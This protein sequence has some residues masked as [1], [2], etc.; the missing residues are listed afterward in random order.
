MGDGDQGSDA[1]VPQPYE[2]QCVWCGCSGQKCGHR[3]TVT[4]H[5][6]AQHRV[7]S[8]RHGQVCKLD[9]VVGML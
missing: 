1:E 6:T 4:Q 3:G 8:A 2:P 9:H 5:Q 7:G